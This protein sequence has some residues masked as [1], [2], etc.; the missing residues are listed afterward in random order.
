[1]QEKMAKAGP[2]KL[3][4]YQWFFQF[5]FPIFI[6][7]VRFPRLI[8]AIAAFFM[9]CFC[10]VKPEYLQAVISN[11]KVI[12][13]DM[14]YAEL[15]KMA[16]RMLNNHSRYWIEFFRY[17][18]KADL[19]ERC[20]EDPVQ[21]V[22]S[23]EKVLSTNGAIL[24]TAHMGNWELGGVFMS[25]LGCSAN[26]V[27]VKDR[28]DIV[29]RVRSK[30]R[31]FGQVKEIPIS[32]GLFAALP[33]LRALDSG[34]YLAMQGDRDFNDRGIPATFFGHECTF[35]EGPYVLALVSGVPI[36]PSF[37]LYGS[38]LGSYRILAFD[39]LIVPERGTKREK[40][41]SLLQ[42]YLVILEEIILEYPDQWYTFYP[43]FEHP[44]PTSEPLDSRVTSDTG[45]MVNQ[46]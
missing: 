24:I 22:A 13:P 28:F 16:F 38:K 39:P 14:P 43:F 15:K 37:V 40:I 19:L 36:I 9:R 46:A 44:Q 2:I 21:A 35:P 5:W 42:Q 1:M 18:R 27:Y 10:W 34:E 20:L 41:Q 29:E 12:F 25:R 8:R 32:Q 45:D 31:S 11:Y 6:F 17:A 33:A 26:V 30:F 23:T 4:L 7:L 3:K